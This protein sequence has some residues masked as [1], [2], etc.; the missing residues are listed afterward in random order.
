MLFFIVYNSKMEGKMKIFF[1]MDGTLSE[2][3]KTAGPDKWSAPGYART[4]KPLENVVGAVKA[5][6]RN[7]K[8]FSEKVEVFICS[9][10]VSMDYAVEDKIAWLKEQ[11]IDIPRENMIF[12]PYG[13]SKAKAI[14]DSGITIEDGD[15]FVDDY[16]KNLQEVHY[17]T[18]LVA[19]KLL[20]GINDTNKSWKFDR[21]SAFSCP[22][23]IQRQ[24][25]GIGLLSKAS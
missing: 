9:A 2:F 13:R 24:L 23:S 7:Q 5:F 15:L 10:V 21:I 18:K 12:V 14:L 16:T 8:Y 25:I 22:A 11:G 6:I 4:L 20:N 1:D 17:N 3:D 19:V